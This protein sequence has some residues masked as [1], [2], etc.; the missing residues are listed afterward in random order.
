MTGDGPCRHDSG[1]GAWDD[2]D[3]DVDENYDDEYD[4]DYY[5]DDNDEITRARSLFCT[6]YRAIVFDSQT[7]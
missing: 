2:D 5:D 6:M 1:E 4:D 3:D 7:Q